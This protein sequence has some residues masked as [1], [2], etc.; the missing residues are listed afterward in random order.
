MTG[1]VADSIPGLVSDI[2]VI[3]DSAYNYSRYKNNRWSRGQTFVEV[4]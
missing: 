4:L 3:F 1:Q 2:T